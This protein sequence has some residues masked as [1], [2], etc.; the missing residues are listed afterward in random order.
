MQDGKVVNTKDIKCW[1]CSKKGH[2]QSNCPKLK[3][4]V[5]G[6]DDG[7]QN[8][9][10][11]EFNDGHSL[12]LT[13]EEDKC[14]FVQNKG[15]ELIL[16]PDHLYIDRC[17]SYPSMPYAHLLDN[18]M[19]KLRSLCGHMNSGS[20]V[21]DMVGDF[22]AIKKKWLNKCGV[23]SSCPLKV[24][25]KIWPNSYHSK[26]GMNPGH[27]IIHTNEGDI[28][29]KNNSCR[30]PFLNLKEVEAEAEVALCLIQDTI[31]AVWINMEGFTKREVEEAKA[32]RKA[33]GMLGHPMDCKFLRMVHLNM[34]S[35]SSI[36]KNTGKNNILIFGP[37]LAGVRG[38]TVR[39][40]LKLVS[41]NYVQMSRMILDWHQI[42]TL[43]V[44]CIFVNGVAFLFSMSRRLNLITAK[45]TQSQTAKN[46][47]A[48]INCIMELYAKGG[49]Q[50]GIVLMD[51]KFESLHTCTN[52]CHQ[53]N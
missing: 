9:T 22:G 15:T 48:G 32:T 18:L 38:R 26:R 31:E 24:L 17:A 53:Y 5:I 30:M 10:I 20:T 34:I 2:Y 4:K 45:H 43:A 41:I 39:R 33:Q 23:A 7:I 40:P 1:Y 52:H 3:V 16:L 14:M 28:V 50:V 42:V 27:F 46:L 44:D 19:R 47:A 13:N 51:N 11:E 6:V 36:T 35:N 49:F 8:F 12:F 29:V 21:M 25:K 37:D